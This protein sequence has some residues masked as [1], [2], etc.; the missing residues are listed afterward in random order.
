[1]PKVVYAKSCI[2]QIS[3]SSHLSCFFTLAAMK[4]APLNR[5]MH[6]SLKDLLWNLLDI[7]TELRV[8]DHVC[9]SFSPAITKYLRQATL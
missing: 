3:L 7:F 5:H 8:L 9:T 4:N 6:T 2:C 1:M